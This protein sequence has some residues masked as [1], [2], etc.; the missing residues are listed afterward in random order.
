LGF[1]TKT[2]DT[3]WIVSEEKRAGALKKMFKEAGLDE[4]DVIHV[5]PTP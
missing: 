3:R 4:I 2:V 1:P 5:S